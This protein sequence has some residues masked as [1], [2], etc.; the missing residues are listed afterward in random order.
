MDMYL[1]QFS[2][3]RRTI[4]KYLESVDTVTILQITDTTDILY[5][6][7]IIEARSFNFNYVYVPDFGRYYYVK[8][9]DLLDGERIKV[10]LAVD[11]LMSHRTAILGSLV[12][13]DR[14]SS[15]SEPMIPDTVIPFEDTADVY[16]QEQA[17]TCFNSVSYVLSIAGRN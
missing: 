1:Y 10:R 14:S 17:T 3:D 4:N 13:A 11:V 16:I 8:N 15:N 12:M 6:E 5:P 9:I 2:G 7:I